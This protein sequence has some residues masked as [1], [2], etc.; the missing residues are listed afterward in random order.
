DWSMRVQ[1]QL[2]KIYDLER[3]DSR[4]ALGTANA[5]NLKALGE[6]LLALE[7]I[8]PLLEEAHSA[9]LKN[10]SRQWDF[11]PTL[12]SRIFTTLVD[13]PPLS[14][15][16]GGLVRDGVHPELDGLR[17]LQ[18]DAKSAMAAIEERERKRT[19]ISSLKIQFN[20]VFGYYLEVTAAHLSK[21]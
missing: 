15:R 1:T 10:L 14:I 16:D 3:L 12:S 11:F 20:R 8:A 17:R 18:T 5:R 7:R 2:E 13:E 9:F 19:G 21:V 6:S 4:L